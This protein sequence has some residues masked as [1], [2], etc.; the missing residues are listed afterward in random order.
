VSYANDSRTAI[1]GALLLFFSAASVGCGDKRVEHPGGSAGEGG[2][3][4]VNPAA[5]IRDCAPAASGQAGEVTALGSFEW[6]SS[7]PLI[8]PM[9]DDAHPILSVKD[10]SI[11][12]FEDRYH[13]F[14]TTA[15]ETGSWS[16]V[17]LSFGDWSEAASAP[18][19][20]LSDNPV[21][22]GY[23]AAPQV[24]FFAPH[25][26]WYLIFQSGQPQYSTTDDIEKPESWTRPV[27]FFAAEP[28]TVLANKGSGGWLDFWIICDD[29]LCHLFF[30]DDNGSFYRS[31]TSLDDFP[32]GFADPVIALEGTKETLF[33][34]SSTYR[35]DETNQY[36]TLIEAFGPSG[37]RFYRSFVADT[38]DGEWTPLADSWA[39]PFAGTNNVTYESG[40]AWTRDVSH[41]ELIRSGHD[42]RLSVSLSCL[43]FL[44][45][46]APTGSTAVEYFRI[47]Y[48]LALL[49]RAE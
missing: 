28:P 3:P 21:L 12:R 23:H 31:Q 45:Q 8:E 46:G 44:Y 14:A 9:A 49:T 1:L 40:N 39:N 24:F 30:T 43:R 36:L 16:M 4:V 34:G 33:E 42:Q 10:P 47:P 41:G 29:A 19:H 35:V 17:Y 5:T 11:V 20:Y 15:N 13:V 38:L 37:Q 6:S 27:N 7:D 18:Q 48:R 2:G 25:G 26:K 22:A 32:E